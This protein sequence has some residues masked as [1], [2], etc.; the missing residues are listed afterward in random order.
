MTCTLSD[1][2]NL[3]RPL[4]KG[5]VT[6]ARIAAMIAALAGCSSRSA[7]FAPACPRAG[8]LADAADLTRYRPGGGR[9]LTD[10]V[11]EGHIVGISGECAYGETKQDLQ[12]TVTVSFD[13]IRGPAASQAREEDIAIFVAV[14]QSER[15]LDKKLYPI[16]VKFPPNVEKIHLTSAEISLLLPVSAELSGAAYAVTAGFQ[17]T[18]DELGI[19][20]A[21]LPR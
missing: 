11:L 12:T 9:D 6:T 14:T 10:Q 21:R 4:A 15:I 19:N 3:G 5:I 13:V 1:V 20:R 18:P 17:L 7:Q 8:I 16:R 2:G